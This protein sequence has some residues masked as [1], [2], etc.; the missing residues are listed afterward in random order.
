MP[1]ELWKVIVVLPREDAEPRTNSRVISVIMPND[2]SVGFDWT[3]YRT[4]VRAVEKLTGLRFFSAVPD[5]V[6]EALRDHVDDVEVRVAEPRHSGKG[7]RD[8]RPPGEEGPP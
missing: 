7:E 2:Q 1:H 5:D 6:A 3:R 4:S 8:R